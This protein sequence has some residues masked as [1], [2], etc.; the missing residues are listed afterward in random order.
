[1]VLMNLLQGKDGDA[2]V[3]CILTVLS[4]VFSG[5]AIGMRSNMEGHAEQHEVVPLFYKL[6]NHLGKVYMLT[7]KVEKEPKIYAKC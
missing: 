4:R 7:E 2:D 6:P 3:K 5:L 1:M